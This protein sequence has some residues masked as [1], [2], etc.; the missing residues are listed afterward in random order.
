L[1]RS[2]PIFHHTQKK[3]SV[4][5][6][7][8]KR[9]E[10]LRK[11]I[12]SQKIESQI[13]LFKELIA[14]PKMYY[15]KYNAKWQKSNNQ[16]SSMNY[17]LK[18]NKNTKQQI[19]KA[20]VQMQQRY[21]K[22]GKAH[23]LREI[24]QV[25][26]NVAK[27]YYPTFALAFNPE[28]GFVSRNSRR[29]FRPSNASDVINALLNYG[30]SILYA[31]VAKQLNAL[32][33]DCFVG[34]YHKNHSSQLSLV[35]D[36]IEPF[37]H[38]IDRSVF[39]IQNSIRKSDYIFSRQGIVVLSNELKERYIDLLT[40]I[41]DRKRDYKA[42]TGIRRADGYQKMEKITIMKMK[43]LELKDCVFYGRYLSRSAFQ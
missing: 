3:G 29:T 15:N 13:Q 18:I 8:K 42:R 26:G 36:M 43:C 38:L 24:M 41:L 34:F 17:G 10:Y 22:L 19:Q 27:A 16:Y 30:L 7:S 32:G 25:E 37:R 9:L 1:D 11:W 5:Y 39:E 14:E 40:S 12:V 31:E 20:I 21:C 6:P 2:N 35:Y 28:L 33:L 4:T 23:T